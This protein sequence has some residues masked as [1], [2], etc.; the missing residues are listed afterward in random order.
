MDVS[1]GPEEFRKALGRL[2]A[3]TDKVRTRISA[4]HQIHAIPWVVQNSNLQAT[5]NYL[6]LPHICHSSCCSAH[7][8]Y[9]VRL[10]TLTCWD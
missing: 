2:E 5:V 8:I 10:F 3:K 7:P 1:L 9:A 6:M 4:L